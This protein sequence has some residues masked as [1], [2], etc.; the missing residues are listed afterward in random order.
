VVVHHR[1][2]K[3]LPKAEMAKYWDADVEDIRLDVEN[4]LLEGRG[5]IGLADPTLPE[6][7]KKVAEEK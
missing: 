7:V 4:R 3:E 6:I 2:V 1:P 5:V